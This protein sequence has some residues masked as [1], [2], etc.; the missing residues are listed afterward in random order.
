[1]RHFTV[2]Q[3]S[4]IAVLLLTLPAQAEGVMKCKVT[5]VTH[6]KCT[7]YLLLERA[8]LTISDVDRFSFQGRYS[9]CYHGE[10]V[11]ITGRVKHFSYNDGEEFE[12]LA[13]E[14]QLLP[15]GVQ[16]FPRTIGTITLKKGSWNG[17]FFDIWNSIRTRGLYPQVPFTRVISCENDD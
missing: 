17:Y 16:L 12:L 7:P 4:I 2:G 6:E 10:D 5:P 1:M 14:I 9:S 15:T 13:T 3:T 8:N 11:A